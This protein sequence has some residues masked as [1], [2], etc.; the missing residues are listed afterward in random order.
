MSKAEIIPP[1]DF[2]RCFLV[3]LGRLIF[4]LSISKSSAFKA[5]FRFRLK[6]TGFRFRLQQKKNGGN[7]TR[8][9]VGVSGLRGI[10]GC[11]DVPGS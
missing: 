3:F 11:L 4:F 10:C 7:E 5:F 9:V 1:E 2:Y 8:Q 6:K